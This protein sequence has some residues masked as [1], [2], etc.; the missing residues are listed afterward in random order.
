MTTWRDHLTASGRNVPDA[1]STAGR[2]VVVVEA[3]LVVDVAA[4]EEVG[5]TV[6][7]VQPANTTTAKTASGERARETIRTISTSGELSLR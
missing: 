6:T 1:S 4:V 3:A 7:L 5:G 2:V